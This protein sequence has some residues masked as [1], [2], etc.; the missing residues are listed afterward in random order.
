MTRM[1]AALATDWAG[2][3]KRELSET[4]AMT[5]GRGR[6]QGDATGH[7][8]LPRRSAGSGASARGAAAASQEYEPDDVS[9]ALFRTLADNW[10]HPA[11][12]DAGLALA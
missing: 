11:I 9:A 7:A 10:G 12:R 2:H 5:G 4:G 3:R 1:A 8:E 6:R